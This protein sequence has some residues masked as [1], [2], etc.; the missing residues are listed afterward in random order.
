MVILKGSRE[1]RSSVNIYSSNNEKRLKSDSNASVPMHDQNNSSSSSITS[2]AAIDCSSPRNVRGRRRGRCSTSDDVLPLFNASNTSCDSS[3]SEKSQEQ[4]RSSSKER[5]ISRNYSGSSAISSMVEHTKAR[6][7]IQAA[8]GWAG[9][10]QIAMIFI[11]VMLVLHSRSGADFT[12]KTLERL[13]Q[14]ESLSLLQLQKIERQS[15]TLHENIRRRLQMEGVLQENEN[16]PLEPQHRQ[17]EKMTS[18]IDSQVVTLQKRIQLEARKEIIKTYGEGPIKVLIEL[19]F[20]TDDAEILAKKKTT[21]VTSSNQI[22]IALLPE[23][24]HAV[25]TL[26]DQ[27]GSG[28]WDGAGLEW[29]TMS[30]I[31]Q[32]RPTKAPTSPRRRSLEFVESHPSDPQTNPAFHHG[33]WTVGLRESISEDDLDAANVADDTSSSQNRLELF[34]NLADNREALKHETCIGKILDGFYAL[35]RL[36]EATRMQEGKVI[37]NIKVK[38]ITAMHI[39]NHEVNQIF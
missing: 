5:R 36:L 18:E 3:G 25:W 24:P 23:T 26:L 33:P 17:L 4:T 12:E 7:Y 15:L 38:S 30:N 27:V 13:R 34:I 32:F 28:L 14:E 2:F 1:S 8:F 9:I 39:T 31:L 29:D 22:S 16:D 19:D 6:L 10:T 11:I 21:D 20:E 35:Q 37:T